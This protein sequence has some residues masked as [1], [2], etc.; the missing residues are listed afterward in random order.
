MTLIPA[1]VQELLKIFVG[2]EGLNP[3]PDGIGFLIFGD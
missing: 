1:L 3:P 2:G